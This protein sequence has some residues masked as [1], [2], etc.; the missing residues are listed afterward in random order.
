MKKEHTDDQNRQ[1]NA[2]DEH[3]EAHGHEENIQQE[4][5]EIVESDEDQTEL[6]EEATEVDELAEAK[7]KYLRLYS[8]F[9]NYRRRTS[10]EK[11]DLIQ[12]AGE[13]VILDMLPVLDDFGRA[14]DSK[15]GQS[16]E[17]II[18]GME[19]ISQ[20]FQKIMVDQGLTQMDTKPGTPFDP[21]LH[22]AVTQIPAPSKKFIGN[23]VDTIEQGYLLGDKVIRYAKVV[24]GA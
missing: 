19:L 13:K 6:E 15:E 23:I 9:D 18:E 16:S 24:I 12:T 17:A 2:S 14:A 5:E 7:D 10:K 1:N 4:A 11:L 8:E 20:K 22:E 21:E 3:S